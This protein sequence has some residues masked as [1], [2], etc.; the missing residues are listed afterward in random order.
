M[1]ATVWADVWK[2]H[3]TNEVAEITSFDQ[4]WIEALLERCT[5]SRNRSLRRFWRR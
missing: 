4:R 3:S 1:S 5:A 2:G